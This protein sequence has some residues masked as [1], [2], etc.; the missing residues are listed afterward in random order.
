MSGPKGKT[1]VGTTEEEDEEV[2]MYLENFGRMNLVRAF[3]LGAG[4]VVDLTTA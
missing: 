4:G 1:E 2:R 3:Q